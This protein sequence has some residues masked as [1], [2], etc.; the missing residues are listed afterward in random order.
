VGWL[1]AVSKAGVGITALWLFW[2]N[3]TPA[4]YP[5]VCLLC[6]GGLVQTDLEASGVLQVSKLLLLLE[7]YSCRST[8]NCSQSGLQQ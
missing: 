7:A 8:A 2:S 1:S 3:P 4:L 5:Y 6:P